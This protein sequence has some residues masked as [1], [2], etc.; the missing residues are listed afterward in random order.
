MKGRVTVRV[1][2]RAH[3]GVKVA[4][5]AVCDLPSTILVYTCLTQLRFARTD[6]N[7]NDFL[8]L[9]PRKFQLFQF[10]QFSVLRLFVLLHSG[11]YFSTHFQEGIRFSFWGP[12][13]L[14]ERLHP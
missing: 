1:S 8:L 4:L 13:L 7:T 2:W 11:V 12:P 3:D 14:V 5:A 9:I 6:T 10:S